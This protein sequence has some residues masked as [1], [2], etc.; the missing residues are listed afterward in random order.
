MGRGREAGHVSP[1]LGQDPLGR[2]LTDTG[3]R[4]GE[5]E[6]G[7]ERAHPLLDLGRQAGDLGLEEVDVPE[8][9]REEAALVGT[10]QALQCGHEAVV[11]VA[12]PALGHSRE[13][14]R[15]VASFDERGE[16]RPA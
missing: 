3:D 9:G 6:G 2:P 13:E 14:L 10:D 7:N 4:V 8:L 1:D 5:R 15:V 16:H 12:Q 11:L